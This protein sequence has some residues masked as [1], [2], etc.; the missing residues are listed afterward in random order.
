MGNNCFEHPRVKGCR[1]VPL[2]PAKTIPFIQ[3][4]LIFV[5]LYLARLEFVNLEFF[6]EVH[7]E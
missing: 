3:P 7:F 4:Q 6:N 1:R 5:T 2:P